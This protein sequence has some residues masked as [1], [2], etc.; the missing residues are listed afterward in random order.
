MTL[1][2]LVDASGEAFAPAD[3]PQRIVSLIPSTTELLC[4]LGLADRLV[5]VTAYCVEPR[6]IVRAKTRIGGEKDPDLEKIRALA[7]DLVIANVEENVRAHID[8]LRGWGLRVW[9]TYPRTVAESLRML[10]EL[11]AVTGTGARAEALA[12]TLEGELA[13]VGAATGQHAR[14]RLL[15]D[16]AQ[17]VHD[18]E[19]RHVHLGRAG[20]LWRGQRLRGCLR[21]GTPR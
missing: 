16:L 4:D 9:V 19:R 3:P 20:H 6:E 17:P 12:T 2:A 10:R 11:G 8:T 1:A 15:R 5:G 18:G 21:R 7:P 13:A 14:A